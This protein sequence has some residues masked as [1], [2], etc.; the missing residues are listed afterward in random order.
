[1]A[2]HRSSQPAA[3]ALSAV[4]AELGACSAASPAPLI[5]W[6][7]LNPAAVQAEIDGLVTAAA[8][9]RAD[10]LDEILSQA[11]EFISYFLNLLTANPG[12]YPQTTKVLTI[13]SQVGTF[14]AMYFK[15][16]YKRPRASELCPALLPPIEVPGPRLVPKRPF[17]AGASDGAVHERYA[18]TTPSADRTRCWKIYGRWPIASRA[19]AR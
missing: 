1:M 15:G 4:L 18:S 13:A 12:A 7:T 2:N 17:D 3:S 5:D 10:A 6:A 9:E 19:T 11:N 8:N 16:L 14:V